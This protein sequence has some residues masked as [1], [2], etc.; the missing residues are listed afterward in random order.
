MTTIQI[1]GL[2]R[3][4][5]QLSSLT[6]AQMNNAIANAI[7][8]VAFQKVRPAMQNEMKAVFDRVT[9]YMVNSVSVYRKATANRLEAVIAPYYMGGKG[10]DPEKVLAAEVMGGTRHDKRS[11]KAFRSV[12]MLPAGYQTSIPSTPFPGSDD[13]RGNLKGSFLVQL[14]SYFQGFGEMGYRANMK[15][16]RKSKLANVGV[17][18]SGYKTINGVSYFVSPAG[19]K[20]VFDSKNRASHLAPGIWARQG[21]HGSNIKPV[22]MFVKTPLYTPRFSLKRIV[23]A[24]G[25]AEAMSTKIRYRIRNEAGV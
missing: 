4:Q 12:G 13:G 15:A 19:M 20:G 14:I 3:V 1:T 16:K 18:E 7:N 24:S 2:E 5:R 25:V 8:D 11:E 9:P 21:I 17:T 22:L 6:G 23:D 10:I